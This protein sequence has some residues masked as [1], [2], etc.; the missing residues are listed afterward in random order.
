MAR[1]D[2]LTVPQG[3]WLQLTNADAT[4]VTFQVKSGAVYI[5][6]TV[7][8]VAPTDLDNALYYIA[9]QGE[10]AIA[11]VDLAPGTAGANRLYAWGDASISSSVYISHA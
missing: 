1:T 2:T 7:G 4:A 8:A 9:G 5:A 3:T 6:T 11:M 10:A